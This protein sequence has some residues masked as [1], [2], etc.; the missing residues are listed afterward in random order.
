M[1]DFQ[2]G[3]GKEI[4]Y[5]IELCIKKLFI[6]LNPIWILLFI[7][8][9]RTEMH[10]TFN[11]E[12]LSFFQIPVKDQ[13]HQL[14]CISENKLILYEERQSYVN[15]KEYQL[16]VKWLQVIK[17]RQYNQKDIWKLLF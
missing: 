1:H 9:R 6:T 10:A 16:N 7:F 15:S 13:L 8:H 17:C 14:I 12:I 11:S 2:I 4:V 3:K 5:N